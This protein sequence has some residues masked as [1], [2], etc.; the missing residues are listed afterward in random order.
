MVHDERR[1]PSP[2]ETQL[3]VRPPKNVRRPAHLRLGLRLLL[4]SR[5]LGNVREHGC[6]LGRLEVLGARLLKQSLRL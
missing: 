5:L 1:D 3:I 6:A 2:K 4:G